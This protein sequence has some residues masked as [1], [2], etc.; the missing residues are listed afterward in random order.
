MSRKSVVA[1]VMRRR[2]FEAAL[3]PLIGAARRKGRRREP[4]PTRRLLPQRWFS[5]AQRRATTIPD[6]VSIAVIAIDRIG[7]ASVRAGLTGKEVE[8]A[9]PDEES[10]AIL[11]AA[12]AETAQ[13]RATDR[14]V[15]IR[16]ESRAAL[17]RD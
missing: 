11:R 12:L 15:K 10:A 5:R 16:A 7:R 9:A 4:R 17:L 6:P 3:A 14:L 2:A 13:W 1:D 8:V